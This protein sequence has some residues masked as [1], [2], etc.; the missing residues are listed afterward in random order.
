M[1]KYYKRFSEVEGLKHPALTNII[2]ETI[3]KYGTF[4]GSLPLLEKLW[5][6]FSEEYYSRFL[7]PDNGSISD[8]INW[9]DEH[10]I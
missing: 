8:F 1:G 6:E 10:D 3:S 9:L 7:M 5:G 2:F 4:K